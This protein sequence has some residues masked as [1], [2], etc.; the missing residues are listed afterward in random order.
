MKTRFSA[1]RGYR[2]RPRKWLKIY[3]YSESVL[4][5]VNHPSLFRNI[6]Y[7][8]SKRSSII[9]IKDK[10]SLITTASAM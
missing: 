5:K 2:K 10:Q 3:N 4:A 7:E 8:T 1:F 6:L 9:F